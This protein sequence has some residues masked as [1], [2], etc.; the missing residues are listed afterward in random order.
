MSALGEAR[1]DTAQSE[2]LVGGSFQMHNARGGRE[3]EEHSMS[4]IVFGSLTLAS[5]VLFASTF[6][7][8]N[9]FA[10][11]YCIKLTRA[12]FPHSA[13]RR[14]HD[15]TCGD[16]RAAELAMDRSLTAVKPQCVN[17][18]TL[19]IAERACSRVNMIVNTSAINA[20]AVWPPQPQSSQDKVAYFAHGI[21]PAT[22]LNLCGVSRVVSSTVRRV[23]DGRCDTNSGFTPLRTDTTVHARA[24]CGIV[25][26]T[27]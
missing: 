13:L 21:G 15:N 10:W 2:W 14:G 24:H 1:P 23:V 3:P 27:P 17:N 9:A 18:I 5:L 12:E 20:F 26:S 6:G 7:S 11:D 25:C 16:S 8:S 19:G 22:T 4:R